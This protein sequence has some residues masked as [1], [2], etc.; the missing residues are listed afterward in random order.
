MRQLSED[1]ERVGHAPA[2]AA[3][4]YAPAALYNDGLGTGPTAGPQAAPTRRTCRAREIQKDAERT[5][6]LA[7]PA[8]ATPP[9]PR[10]RRPPPAGRPPLRRLHA[11]PRARPRH[12]LRQLPG[13]PPRGRPRL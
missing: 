2:R 12:R 11:D 9:P 7:V 1:V 3:R 10:R 13:L 4:R 8:A 6:R 5:R